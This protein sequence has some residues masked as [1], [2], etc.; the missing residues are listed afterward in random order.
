MRPTN[1]GNQSHSITV[2]V[3]VYN[4]QPFLEGFFNALEAMT[5]KNFKTLFV[6]DNSSDGSLE[7]LEKKLASANTLDVTLLKRPQ[8]EGVGKARDYAIESGLIDTPYVIFIDV[9]D[10]PHPDL[11]GKL[12]AQ[13]EK[14]S[15]HITLCGFRRIAIESQKVI[16]VD[17][18]HNP[19]T[20][21]NLVSSPILPYL[22]P[23]PWNKLIRTSI[24]QNARF[25]HKGGSGEDEMFFLQILPRAKKLAFVN[26]VLYDYLVHAGSAATSTEY[27]SY[28]EALSGYLGT[29]QYYLAHP[30]THEKFLPL[31]EACV[32]LRIAVGTTTRVVLAEPKEKRIVIKSSLGYLNKN[33]PTWRKNPYLSHK[34]CAK[35]GFK[36]RMVWWCKRLYIRHHFAFFIWT[37]KTYTK[38]LKKDIKW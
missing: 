9:D 29:K 34:A 37:Y 16:A 38:L 12:F 10:V 20:I 27:L 6:Y 33:F 11:L 24:I 8:K 5:F 35:L 15:A 30:A 23:A 18:V 3:P 21:D 31:L 26:E 32:F 1:M 22:N 17:M 25:I 2:V 19:E 28:Q 7:L 4:A 14:T 13:A 36:T